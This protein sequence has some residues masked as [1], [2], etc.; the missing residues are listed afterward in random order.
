MLVLLQFD[1]TVGEAV[2]APN[3]NT[4][5]V[6]QV[7]AIGAGGVRISYDKASGTYS[8]RDMADGYGATNMRRSRPSGIYDV[9]SKQV[10][11]IFDEDKDCTI[12]LARTVRLSH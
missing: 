6:E 10:P 3:G 4:S 1:A 9:Y 11:G 12:L 8:V 2:I 5:Y 7:G